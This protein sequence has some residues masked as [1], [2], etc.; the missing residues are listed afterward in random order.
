[1]MGKKKTIGLDLFFVL[2]EQIKISC[3]GR[4]VYRG[5]NKSEFFFC[6]ILSLAMKYL[7]LNE[8]FNFK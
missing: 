1:M 8:I 3:S 7:V 4:S 2:R 6:N 5:G